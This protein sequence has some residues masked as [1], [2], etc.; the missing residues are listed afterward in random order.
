MK[1]T[2]DEL[3]T[4]VRDV[5]AEMVSAN[6]I[7]PED[8]QPDSML[9]ADLGFASVDTIHMM[10]SLQDRVK[11]DLDMEGLVLK[12]GQYVPDLAVGDLH[13]YVSRQL[14]LPA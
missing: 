7:D 12:D 13:D 10:I 14:D 4:I 1:P 8:I 6:G 3:W 5:V 11:S 9:V 2:R